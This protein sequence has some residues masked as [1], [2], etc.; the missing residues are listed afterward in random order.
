MMYLKLYRWKKNNMKNVLWKNQ[1]FEG[2]T[3]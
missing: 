1:E 2:L 3:K